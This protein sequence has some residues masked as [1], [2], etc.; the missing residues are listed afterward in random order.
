MTLDLAHAV[1]L[2]FGCR[3]RISFADNAKQGDYPVDAMYGHPDGP[4]IGGSLTFAESIRNYL[5]YIY[6]CICISKKYARMY[7]YA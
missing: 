1:G 3:F 6:I 4:L 7:M 2:A 5:L